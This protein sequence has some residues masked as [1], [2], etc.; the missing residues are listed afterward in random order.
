MPPKLNSAASDIC[1]DRFELFGKYVATSIRIYGR[2]N[3]SAIRKLVHRLTQ[4]PNLLYIQ[5]P[6]SLDSS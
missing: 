6:L 2:N 5:C 3:F 1:K 4:Q